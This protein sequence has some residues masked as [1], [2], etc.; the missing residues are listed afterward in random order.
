[1]ETFSIS[2]ALRLLK[3]ET[4]SYLFLFWF[5]RYEFLKNESVVESYF[6]L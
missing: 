6:L 4:F 3:V 5:R 1:M 2:R